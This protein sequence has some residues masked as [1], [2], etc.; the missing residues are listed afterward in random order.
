MSICLDWLWYEINVLL[1]GMRT[2][3]SYIGHIVCLEMYRKAVAGWQAHAVVGQG[4]VSCTPERSTFYLQAL[5]IKSISTT[6]HSECLLNTILEHERSTAGTAP[7]RGW[8]SS[9]RTTVKRACVSLVHLVVDRQVLHITL[10]KPVDL[11]A[12][13][14][15]LPS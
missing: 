13:T 8:R 3:D 5:P 11:I 1:H 12:S 7:V 14:S 2:C 10:C 9:G 4:P 15:R 6:K